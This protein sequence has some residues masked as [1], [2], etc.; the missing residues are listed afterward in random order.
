[1]PNTPAL[2]KATPQHTLDIGSATQTRVCSCKKSRCLKLYCECFAAGD[3]CDQCKCVDCANDGQHEAQRLQAVENIKQRNSN[4]FAPKIVDEEQDQ[5][6]GA[7][8]RGCRCKKS[9]CLKKYCECFQYVASPQ[10]FLLQSFP[11]PS[12]LPCA[13]TSI[14]CSCVRD[15]HVASRE[16]I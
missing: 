1:M 7:H 9:H 16:W 8:A 10:P 13:S 5:P 12:A 14:A 15:L 2:D 6:V 4:A 3:L 11:P